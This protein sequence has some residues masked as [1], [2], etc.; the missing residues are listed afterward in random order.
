VYFLEAAGFGSASPADGPAKHALLAH[1]FVAGIVVAE[2]D[3]R[4]LWRP[5]GHGRV[6]EPGRRAPRCVRV[7]PPMARVMV[8]RTR[9]GAITASGATV[10]TGATAT[11][12]TGTA[13]AA[14]GAALEVLCD[15][16]GGV[17]GDD[18]GGAVVLRR[19]RGR[20]GRGSVAERK[21]G[22]GLRGDGAHGA[23]D[24]LFRGLGVHCDVFV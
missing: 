10:P 20:V 17:D 22:V 9:R 1:L 7:E 2:P 23:K 12:P 21:V 16:R 11:A 6:P 18:P 19:A 13:A 3:E 5:R 4:G 14:A 15:W 24:L 8:R